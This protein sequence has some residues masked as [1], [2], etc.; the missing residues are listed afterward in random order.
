MKGMAPAALAAVPILAPLSRDEKLTLLDA[1]EEHRFAPKQ[2]VVRQVGRG[3]GYWCAGPAAFGQ[4]I[5]LP[6]RASA[7]P[8]RI[9]CVGQLVVR[10]AVCVFSALQGEPGDLFYIIKEGEAV[11]YQDTGGGSRKRVNQLFKADFFGEGAL[12]SDEPRCVGVGGAAWQG[13][14]QTGV[15]DRA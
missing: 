8:A 3:W 2:T 15:F 1:F 6:W 10:T 4:R 9:L 11:V 13:C 5:C 7:T 14:M 12:L